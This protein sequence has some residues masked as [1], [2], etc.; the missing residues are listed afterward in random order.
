S[1]HTGQF[2]QEQPKMECEEYSQAETDEKD[3]EKN[4]KPADILPIALTIFLETF[5]Y[6]YFDGL[7]LD[8]LAREPA[9][10]HLADTMVLKCEPAFGVLVLTYG[11]DPAQLLAEFI[12]EDVW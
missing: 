10:Q 5:P 1:Y 3:A 2:N 11:S 4:D 7:V 12:E 9:D 8:P 6:L